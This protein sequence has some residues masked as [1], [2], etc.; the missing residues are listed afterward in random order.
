MQHDRLTAKL[1]LL[2][3]ALGLVAAAAATAEP[4][5]KITFYVS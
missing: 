2:L 1:F 4:L 5:P 3:T